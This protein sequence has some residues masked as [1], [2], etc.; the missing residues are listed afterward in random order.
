MSANR[1]VARL[2]RRF[3]QGLGAAVVLA[4]S[5]GAVAGCAPKPPVAPPAA[6]P[7]VPVSVPVEREVTDHADFTAR[8]V[9][10]N[11]VEVRAHVWGYLERVNFKEGALV[12]K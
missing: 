8:V 2:K 12:K 9:A 3:R 10:V 11:S 5:L 7:T 1:R 4:L 6:T